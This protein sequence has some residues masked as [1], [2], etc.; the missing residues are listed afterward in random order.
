M[1]ENPFVLNGFVLYGIGVAVSTLWWVYKYKRIDRLYRFQSKG[2]RQRPNIITIP[3]STVAFTFFNTIFIG[4]SL[5]TLSRKHIL[6]HEHVHVM[7][8]HS[9]DLMFFEALRILFWFNPLVYLYQRDIAVVHEYIADAEASKDD[10]KSQYY[11]KLLNATFGTQQLSF[12]NTFF[13]HSLIKKRVMM[14]QKSKSKKIAKTKYL[15]LIP[16]TFMIIFYVSCVQD[17]AVDPGVNSEGFVEK[18]IELPPPPP[19]VDTEWFQDFATAWTSGTTWDEVKHAVREKGLIVLHEYPKNEEE[20]KTFF[21]E[22]RIIVLSSDKGEKYISEANYKMIVKTLG[23]DYGIDDEQ[24]VVKTYSEAVPF[25]VLERVPVFPGCESPTTDN[26]ELKK[27][28]TQKISAYIAENFNTKIGKELG[29]TGVNR[30]M[31]SFKVDKRGHIMNVKARAPFPQ[32]EE[33]AIRV[34]LGLPIMRPGEQ[35]GK[36][37]DVNYSLPITFYNRII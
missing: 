15:S 27:C 4:G 33:E 14:L 35:D 11:Q 21:D 32:L 25:A 23:R 6:T 3:N 16:L 1:T 37:V 2:E 20:L 12:V 28:T 9:W 22:G 8:G 36:T 17:E 26:T 7:Q 19:P 30:I 24:E 5:N 31:I 18:E 13:N 10:H 29:L 34:V